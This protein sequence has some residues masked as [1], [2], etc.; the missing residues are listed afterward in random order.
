M[1]LCQEDNDSIMRETGTFPCMQRGQ[2]LERAEKQAQDDICGQ[3]SKQATPF[4]FQEPEQ[5]V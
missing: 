1:C 2:T 5:A 3:M 4:S